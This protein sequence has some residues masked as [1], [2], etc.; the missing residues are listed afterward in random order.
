M[1]SW[2]PCAWTLSESCIGLVVHGCHQ[3]GQDATVSS[4]ENT[5]FQQTIADRILQGGWHDPQK[6]WRSD[7]PLNLAGHSCSF[8]NGHWIFH[9][10]R[11][12]LASICCHRHPQMSQLVLNHSLILHV[13]GTQIS[14]KIVSF[15]RTDRPSDPLLVFKDRDP[16]NYVGKW[17]QSRLRFAAP[18]LRPVSCFV[19][20]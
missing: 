16:K 1:E 13:H 6:N 12:T 18:K 8:G 9:S 5:V 11:H 3:E 20:E 10:R 14:L 15:H 7:A 4:W 2:A 19:N 17:H